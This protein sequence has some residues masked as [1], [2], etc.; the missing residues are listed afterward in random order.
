MKSEK[1]LTLTAL[2]IYVLIA[3]IAISSVALLSTYFFSNMNTIKE[4][5]QY[6]PEFNKFSMFFIEDTKN[7]SSAVVN[8][9][10]ITFEDGT[11][12][13][14]RASEKAIYRGETKIAERVD[15]L[16]FTSSEAK[17]NNTTKQVINVKMR[18]QGVQN[19]ENG[20]EYV[21]KYW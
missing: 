5:S 18:I 10:K 1:G 2:I 11:V 3:T 14:Y 9:N 21:L 20:I 19:A 13:E 15:T 6:A 16:T 7:N 17:V 12:Y 4:Q 8:S